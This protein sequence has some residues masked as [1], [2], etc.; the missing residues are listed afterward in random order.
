MRLWKT[1]WFSRHVT[2]FD[3]HVIN[4]THKIKY[5]GDNNIQEQVEKACAES[6]KLSHVERLSEN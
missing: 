5:Y 6:Y 3:I 1:H 4:K 2:G